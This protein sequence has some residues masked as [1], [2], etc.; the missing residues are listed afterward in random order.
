MLDEH[1]M[2][3]TIL[4]MDGRRTEVVNDIHL[5]ESKGRMVARPRRYFLQR[6]L[7]DGAWAACAC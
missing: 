2:G 7:A 5:L 1:L 6:L 4:D 3:K